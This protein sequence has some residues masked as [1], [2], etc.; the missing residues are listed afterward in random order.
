MRKKKRK[1][2]CQFMG[3]LSFS[4]QVVAQIRILEDKK[5]EDEPKHVEIKK[6][7][8]LHSNGFERNYLLIKN[9]DFAVDFQV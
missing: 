9:K 8:K 4:V 1:G 2:L 6:D 3:G 7:S 5:H